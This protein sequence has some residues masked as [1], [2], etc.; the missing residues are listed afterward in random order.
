MIGEKLN[1]PVVSLST[2]EI[3]KHFEWM[4]RFISIDSPA[5]NLITQEQLS[6]KPTHIDLLE[7]MRKNYFL[8]NKKTE[9]EY[10]K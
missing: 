3:E 1:L 4:S 8:I 7:D 10:K 6:W 2:D 5:S 9:N